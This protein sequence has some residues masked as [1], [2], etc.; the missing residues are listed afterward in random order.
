VL[1]LIPRNSSWVLLFEL[2]HSNLIQ[3]FVTCTVESGLLNAVI[4]IFNHCNNVGVWYLILYKSNLAVSTFSYSPEGQQKTVVYLPCSCEAHFYRVIYTFTFLE[5]KIL[6]NSC[7][8]C[9][10]YLHLNNAHSLI[11]WT[12]N[13]NFDILLI[14]HLSI[15]IL[16]LT[17][18]MYY[19]L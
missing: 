10:T 8:K 12:T 2:F 19:I 3:S 14:V 15:F 13:A 16:I 11:Y 7:N 17:N 1:R 5:S 4:L 6:F 9:F 18:L